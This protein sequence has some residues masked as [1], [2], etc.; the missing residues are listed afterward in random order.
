VTGT[1]TPRSAVLGISGYGVAY[2]KYHLHAVGGRPVL[3]GTYG[4][5]GRTVQEKEPGYI[6]GMDVYTGKLPL[7][8]QYLW[9]NYH[10]QS[11]GIDEPPVDFTWEREWRVKPSG[12]GLPV[13][14]E[15]DIW[16]DPKGVILVEQDVD[17][18]VV[19]DCITT[20]AFTDMRWKY[21]ISRVAS[22]ETAD[23]MIREGDSRFGRFDTWPFPPP[24]PN[25]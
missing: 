7:E 16:Y 17:I 6:A 22:L 12:P 2:H 23:R 1:F 21:Y 3:Y 20:L 25:R 13:M 24:P 8:L 9:V 5:L 18:P 11:T 10:P 4:E 19:A 14:S 15:I